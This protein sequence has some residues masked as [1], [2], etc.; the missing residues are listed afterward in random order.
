MPGTSWSGVR[1]I[2]RVPV[3]LRVRASTELEL[4]A[5]DDPRGRGSIWP[6]GL[7]AMSWRATD[8]LDVAAAMEAASRPSVERE[9]TA[10]LRASYTWGRR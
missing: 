9:V 3:T 7:V 5:P 2:A 1:G 10:L 8:Q 4:A 6:W